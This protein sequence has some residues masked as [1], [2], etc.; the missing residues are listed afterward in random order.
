[1]KKFT[2]FTLIA[3]IGI[4]TLFVSACST[5]APV[6]NNQA[7]TLSKESV[8]T[9]KQGTVTSV[10]NVAIAGKRGS[11]GRTVGAITGSILGSGVPYAG[12]IIGSMIGGAVGGEAEKAA[13]N[14]PGLEITLQLNNGEKVVVTQLAKT[15]FKTG[16]K[17][18]LIMQDQRARV[19]HLQS[20]S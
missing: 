14:K 5:N 3:F 16:D 20:N 4:N 19:A 1:M 11:G 13:T 2:R 18:Q 12:S 15:K 6:T 9:V 7:G 10:K 17:V 8:V